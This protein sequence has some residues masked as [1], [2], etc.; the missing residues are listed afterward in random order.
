MLGAKNTKIPRTRQGLEIPEMRYVHHQEKPAER[1]VA[2]N[3][4]QFG[5]DESSAA[6]I[7][8]S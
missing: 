8:D 5:N 3:E 6:L 4:V 1:A 7:N 2:T